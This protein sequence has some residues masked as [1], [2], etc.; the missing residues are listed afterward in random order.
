[1]KAPQSPQPFPVIIKVKFTKLKPEASGPPWLGHTL[2][3]GV[4]VLLCLTPSMPPLEKRRK[5]SGPVF[6]FSWVSL[7]SGSVS[8]KLREPPASLTLS[9]DSTL[10]PFSSLSL[11]VESL[12]LFQRVTEIPPPPLESLPGSSFFAQ[13]R[14]EIVPASGYPQNVL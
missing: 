4:S 11:R 14:K 8:Q 3:R 1:M 2:P 5:G 7:P 9:L 10:L 13:A 12:P 6:H